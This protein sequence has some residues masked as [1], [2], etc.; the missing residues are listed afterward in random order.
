MNDRDLFNMI[1]WLNKSKMGK[2]LEGHILFQVHCIES[3]EK[4]TNP[5]EA[6]LSES[7]YMTRGALSKLT[8]KLIKKR[9]I[10][11]Y[12]KLEK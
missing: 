11:T 4:N 12:Q 5:N 10:E 8:K 6:N 9:L 7:H 2:S 3:I 1:A